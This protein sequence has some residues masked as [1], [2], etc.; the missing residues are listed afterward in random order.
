[1][2]NHSLWASTT[3]W[4]W[5]T[6]GLWSPV[7]LTHCPARLTHWLHKTCFWERPSCILP[8]SVGLTAEFM[9]SIVR[10]NMGVR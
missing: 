4:Y 2:D 5:G 3:S 7:G 1:M 10:V 8:E 9:S 6:F